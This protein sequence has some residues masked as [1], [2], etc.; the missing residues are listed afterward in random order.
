[1]KAVTYWIATGMLAMLASEAVNAGAAYRVGP[2]C[3]FATIQEAVD[4]IPF[5][6]TGIIR[7]VTGTYNESVFIDSMNVQ[8]IGGH[9][10][11]T[12]TEPNSLSSISA[13]GT[14]LP[15]V[16]FRQ[17]SSLAEPSRDLHLTNLFLV[18]GTGTDAGTIPYPGGGLSVWTN[19]DRIANVHLD[20][21][22]LSFN[23]S[24][25]EG[26]GIAVLGDGSGTVVIDSSTITRN[27]VSGVSPRG[28]GVFCEGDYSIFM[29]GGAI[30]HNDSGTDGG[31]FGHGGGLYLDGC[32]FTW[33]TEGA[34]SPDDGELGFNTAYGNGGGLYAT[35]G[36]EV[37]LLGAHA[38]M[39]TS[40][41]PLRIQ[42]NRAMAGAPSGKG[43]AIYAI[44]TDT[45]VTVGRGWMHDNYASRYGGAVSVEDFAGVLVDR[46]WRLCHHPRKCSRIF[47][48][49]AE[50]GGGAVFAWPDG[51]VAIRR[52]MV[53]DNT[54]GTSGPIEVRG[55]L[56]ARDQGVIFLLDSLMHGAVG[57]GFAIAIENAGAIMNSSTIADTE[58]LAIFGVM[59]EPELRIN[60]SI[61]HETGSIAMAQQ[62]GPLSL[63]SVFTVN[64]LISHSD[65]FSALPGASITR[66]EVNDPEFVD[67]TND[68]YYL[69]PGSPAINYCSALFPDPGVDIDWNSRGI[70]HSGQPDVHGPFD[71]GAYEFPLQI[72]SDRFESP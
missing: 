68:L 14:G 51:S 32:D 30:T 7:I 16:R 49:H 54:T 22:A 43:G 57:A 12:T 48:N 21:V 72:F 25:Y 42:N 60:G 24:E 50:N 63:E 61:I 11:C 29:V 10:D 45:S 62:T 34:S 6:G 5:Q 35:G 56:A 69:R 37:V 53:E 64:C 59:G 71:L 46:D 9:S 4:A 55:V 38:D 31:P 3:T 26:G 41:R 8:L 40:T 36:S 13:A 70:S 17:L 28:G 18:N 2:D 39:L 27:A 33:L 44:G 1:M 65:D 66:A 47:N 19:P 23:S 67:R 58:S 15:V 20:I 52:T